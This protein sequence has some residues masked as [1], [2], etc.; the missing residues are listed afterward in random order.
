[1]AIL[2]L[3]AHARRVVGA[4]AAGEATE[5]APVLFP[6]TSVSSKFT[7]MACREGL[8]GV[9]GTDVAIGV[10]VL[11]LLVEGRGSDGEAEEADEDVGARHDD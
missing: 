11:L 1:M 9:G 8:K 6:T 3:R 7:Y 2:L 10:A 4:G 5:E